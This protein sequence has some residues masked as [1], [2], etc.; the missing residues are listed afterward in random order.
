MFA[1]VWLR[2]GC[3]SIV[4]WMCLESAV[5]HVCAFG[6]RVGD[7]CATEIASV[8]MTVAFPNAGMREGRTRVGGASMSCKA[9]LKESMVWN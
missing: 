3:D 1:A 6:Q 2:V 5:G 7:V 9:R 4:F 8:R